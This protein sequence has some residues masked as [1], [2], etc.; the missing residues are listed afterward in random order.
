MEDAYPSCSRRPSA[1]G[2]FQSVVITNHH[3]LKVL[4]A[5]LRMYYTGCVD[6]P[7]FVH[8]RCNSFSPRLFCTLMIL[9][10]LT[11]PDICTQGISQSLISRIMNSKVT[12]MHPMRIS[13][14][15]AHDVLI[16]GPVSGIDLGTT[17]SCVSV[18]DGQQA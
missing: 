9:L 1:L 13:T 4:Q 11:L 3:T 5:L 15:F 17:D 10:S 6:A 18:M 7:F 2:N 16:P 8:A 12:G 14:K